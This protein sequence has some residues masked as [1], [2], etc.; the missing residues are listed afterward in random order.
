MTYIKWIWLLIIWR[1][2]TIG[3]IFNVVTIIRM[4]LYLKWVFFLKF[5]NTLV[6]NIILKTYTQ[7]Y[8]FIWSTISPK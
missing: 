1:D 5:I 3:K 7:S 8:F 4:L 6:F 2:L